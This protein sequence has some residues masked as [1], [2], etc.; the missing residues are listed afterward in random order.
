MEIVNFDQAQFQKVGARGICPHCS[1]MSAFEPVGAA[2]RETRADPKGGVSHNYI[3]QVAKCI[4]CAKFIL[5]VGF[6]Q[7]G[8]Q[9][10]YL[11]QSVAPLGAPKDGVNKSVPEHIAADLAEAIRCEWIKAYKAAVTMCRRAVQ[12]AALDKGATP[13]K[14]LVAQIDELADKQIITASLKDM[15][16]EVRLT[17][18][19]GAHPGEDGL[20]D[21]SP[22]DAKDMIQFTE[23]LFH[24]VYVMPA[25]LKARQT[26]SAPS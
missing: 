21:V 17:G 13:S 18:N 12:A 14:K 2:H 4:S 25:K 5:V 16:H 22:D 9:R 26:P 3:A 1:D 20:N 6:L 23:E 11:L 10:G 15:A 24:H 7:G 19:D 8:L